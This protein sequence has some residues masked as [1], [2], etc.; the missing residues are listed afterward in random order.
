MGKVEKNKFCSIKEKVES[1]KCQLLRR[2]F[3]RILSIQIP[4]LVG[5]KPSKTAWLQA[6]LGLGV[7]EAVEIQAVLYPC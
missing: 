4:E 5:I 2:A 1:V 3:W 6:V 7:E